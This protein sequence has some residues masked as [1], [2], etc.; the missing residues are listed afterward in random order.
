MHW[1]MNFCERRD[2]HVWVYKA[3]LKVF[4]QKLKR[5]VSSSHYC[6]CLYITTNEKETFRC[7]PLPDINV[8]VQGANTDNIIWLHMIRWYYLKHLYQQRQKR[9][10]HIPNIASYLRPKQ[11][12]NDSFIGSNQRTNERTNERM[13]EIVKEKDTR[14]TKTG[15]CTLTSTTKPMTPDTREPRTEREN[16]DL[17]SAVL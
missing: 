11:L 16:N 5:C 9:Q 10:W 12:A 8:S 1:D 6:H 15:D 7:T 14:R 13:N 4:S 3:A 2:H 17:L